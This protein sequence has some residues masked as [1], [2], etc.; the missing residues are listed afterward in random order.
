MTKK[1]SIKDI[2]D[3]AGVSIGTVDRVIHNRGRVSEKTRKRVLEICREMNYEPNVLA[4]RLA[5]DKTYVIATFTPRP[6][7]DNAYWTFPLEGIRKAA[8]E[9]AG[10]RITVKEF[11]FDINDEESFRHESLNLLVSQPDGVVIAPIFHREAEDLVRKLEMKKIPFVFVDSHLENT[12]YLSYFAQDPFRSGYLAGRLIWFHLKKHSEV[13]IVNFT[14]DLENHLHL[15][16]REA[17]LRQFLKDHHFKGHVRSLNI[18]PKDELLLSHTLYENLHHKTRGLFAT[19]S[20]HKVARSI[21]KIRRE[22]LMFVGYDLTPD[23][24]N[25]L[26]QGVIDILLCQKPVA[27]GYGATRALFDH[28]VRKKEVKKE[29]PMPIEIV[30]KENYTDYSDL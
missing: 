6:R 18:S 3:R 24:V 12:G 30:V 29:H 22:E 8:E 25:Y 7:R 27:Q 9:I 11:F 4:Q 21:R 19:S 28:L 20:A 17:G 10:Y 14:S 5:S 13:V 1:V 16:H 26:N 23:N 2:A 15:K